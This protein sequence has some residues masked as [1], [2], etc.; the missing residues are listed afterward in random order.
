MP[1]DAASV[2]RS[3]EGIQNAVTTSLHANCDDT[4]SGGNCIVECS[5]SD[6][7]FQPTARAQCNAGEWTLV[8][9][10]LGLISY[11]DCCLYPDMVGSPFVE[12]C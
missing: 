9:T 7:C 11:G 3:L 2:T 10:C 8:P 4:A 1:C 12:F 6:P 5:M